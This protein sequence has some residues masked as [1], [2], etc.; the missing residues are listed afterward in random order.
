MEEKS[1]KYLIIAVII[2]VIAISLILAIYFFTGKEKPAVEKQP[3]MNQNTN[4]VVIQTPEEQVLS[5]V[6]TL[7]SFGIQ[8][9][10]A[11]KVIQMGAQAESIIKLGDEA[12]N[13]LL[14]QT[15]N[16]SLP[17]RWL[18]IY[19]L[20]RLGHGASETNQTKIVQALK[21]FIDQEK[22]VTLKWQAAAAVY[23]LGEKSVKSI[24]EECANGKDDVILFSEPPGSLNSLCT[25]TLQYYDNINQ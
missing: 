17:V 3:A 6:K 4:A 19:C 13:P 20:A 1:N 12:I 14:K 24:L 15:S 8:T 7:E 5:T 18:T 10:D 16:P 11:E 2:G 22:V 25:K 21:A 9:F 23:G